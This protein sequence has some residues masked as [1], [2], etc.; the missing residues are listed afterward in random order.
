MSDDPVYVVQRALQNETRLHAPPESFYQA[1]P[2][3]LLDHVNH[4]VAVLAV[5]ALRTAGLL[6]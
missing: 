2:G 4:R 5:E 6:P 3:Q 1:S